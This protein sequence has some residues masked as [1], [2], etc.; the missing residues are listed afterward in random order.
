MQQEENAEIETGWLK[1]KREKVEEKHYVK[2]N[3]GHTRKGF[4]SSFDNL[5]QVF[6]TCLLNWIAA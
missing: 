2:L 1:N 4:G 5:F 3:S 6:S